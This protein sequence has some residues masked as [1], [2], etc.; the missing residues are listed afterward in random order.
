MRRWPAGTIGGL[1]PIR[2]HW[3]VASPRGIPD[4]IAARPMERAVGRRE[5]DGEIA[6]ASAP[7][8]PECTNTVHLLAI[9]P[10]DKL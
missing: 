7:T 10:M 9:S 3:R 4:Q 1:T 5:N 2:R 6:V 8:H